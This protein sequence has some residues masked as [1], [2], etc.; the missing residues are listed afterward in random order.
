MR[1]LSTILHHFLQ[2]VHFKRKHKRSYQ[3]TFADKRSYQ[4]TFADKR[5]HQ[6]TFADKRSHQEMF[7]DKRSHQETFADNPTPLV[8]TGP[9]THAPSDLP[10]EKSPLHSNSD[11]FN[12][13]MHE[14]FL[15]IPHLTLCDITFGEWE[16]TVH[17]RN[18]PPIENRDSPSTLPCQQSPV[19]NPPLIAV[20]FAWPAS[21]NLKDLEL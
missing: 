20:G 12:G 15:P 13:R 3:E 18:T 10:V 1:E 5:S 17:H 2:F 4:E 6:E 19:I 14:N 8:A 9:S 11:Q 16:V 7:A 21:N